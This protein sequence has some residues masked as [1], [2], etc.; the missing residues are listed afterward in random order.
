MSD[1]P[2]LK[3]TIQECLTISRALTRMVG[4]YARRHGPDA[5]RT[6][7]IRAVRDAFRRKVQAESDRAVLRQ[8][9]SL[10]SILC[11]E[12][13]DCGESHDPWAAHACRWLELRREAG[14]SWG[15][16]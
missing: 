2:T 10:G 5:A 3:L 6:E 16:G 12:S 7:E 15:S 4:S 14:L 9:D 8:R 1:G 11:R 13:C